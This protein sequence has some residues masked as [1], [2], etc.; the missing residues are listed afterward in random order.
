[1]MDRNEER[2][3]KATMAARMN[4]YLEFVKER[5]S[6]AAFKGATGQDLKDLR[7]AALADGLVIEEAIG[8]SLTE[9]GIWVLATAA[10]DK[11]S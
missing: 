2:G 6:D 4:T 7:Q 5:K 1:M 8:L 3:R 9:K 10:Q 11:R